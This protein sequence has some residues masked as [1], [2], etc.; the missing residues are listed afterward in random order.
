[1][2]Y[3]QNKTIIILFAIFI[4]ISCFNEKK[5]YNNT[6]DNDLQIF[7]VNVLEKSNYRIKKDHLYINDKRYSLSTDSLNI[8]EHLIELEKR[9]ICV[10]KENNEI[11]F[12]G[13]LVK[14]FLEKLYI[15]QIKNSEVKV[16]RYF[17][18][19]YINNNCSK[20]IINDNKY[21]NYYNI[22]RLETIKENV[23]HSLRYEIGLEDCT[24]DIDEE[25][26][27]ELCKFIYKITE[28]RYTKR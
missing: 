16:E 3:I 23:T 26:K 1:M 25:L 6:K 2:R 5:E 27:K 14:N 17:P 24:I 18:E 21:R 8:L 19:I 15:A 9:V 20:I 4:I 13:T 22:I 11:L 28:V 12:S 7:L 10:D